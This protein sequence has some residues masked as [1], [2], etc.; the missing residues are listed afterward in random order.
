MNEP[1]FINFFSVCNHDSGYSYLFNSLEIIFSFFIYLE[2]FLDFQN[3]LFFKY[4]VSFF[5]EIMFFSSLKFY[6]GFCFFKSSWLSLSLVFAHCFKSKIY[7]II[8][9]IHSY[10]K[11]SIKAFQYIKSFGSKSLLFF[12]PSVTATCFL[13]PVLSSSHCRML[14]IDQ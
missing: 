12:H 14:G 4:L 3:N 6:F 7:Y 11:F 8:C 10:F 13:V 9:F 1:I 2:N 5:P